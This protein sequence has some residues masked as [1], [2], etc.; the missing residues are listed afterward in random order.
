MLGGTHVSHGKKEEGKSETVQNRGNRL[1]DGGGAT[2]LFLEGEERSS[3]W[4]VLLLGAWGQGPALVRLGLLGSCL[5]VDAVDPKVH[6]VLISSLE[7]VVATV[8]QS[9]T[10]NGEAA[11]DCATYLS[12]KTYFFLV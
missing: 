5:A 9:A 8:G 4:L 12:L 3:L 2:L 10:A 1:V 7:E 11:L 6:L